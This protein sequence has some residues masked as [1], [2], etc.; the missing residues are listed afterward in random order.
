[1]NRNLKEVGSLT[2]IS[3]APF[4]TFFFTYTVTRGPAPQ[5]TQTG[6][7]TNVV[8]A[9]SVNCPA[10]RV[11]RQNGKKLYP[12][13]YA[14]G[15]SP[16]P[17][18]ISFMVGVFDIRSGLSGFINPNDSVFAP[19]NSDRPT[20]QPDSRETSNN[21]TLNLGPSV[22]TLGSV[23]SSGG[24]ANIVTNLGTGA[25]N[26]TIDLSLGKVFTIGPMA[27]SPALTL[28]TATAAQQ[29]GAVIY[30]I[31]I[32]APSG[33]SNRSVGPPGSGLI[34]VIFS[35]SLGGI[36]VRAGGTSTMT[37]ICDGSNLY[38]VSRTEL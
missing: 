33:G 7:L 2:Y 12:P 4:N 8:G 18:V 5:F 17:G 14:G 38:E 9:T 34:N 6:T 23:T 22:L 27:G 21:A 16:Y 20:Y 35:P 31:M 10:G 11:L 13:S 24:V 1:M 30:I 26:I 28:N 19:F 37:F 15:P 32:G 25:T 36:Q 3:T 29:V